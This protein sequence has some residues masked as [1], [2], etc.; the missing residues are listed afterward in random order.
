MAERLNAL[1]WKGSICESVSGVRIPLSPQ[2]M[3]KFTNTQ[4][5]NIENFHKAKVEA[6][7]GF[8]DFVPQEF[9]DDPVE[10]FER[11]GKNIKTGEIKYDDAGVVRE[12]PTAV[13][14]LPAWK[15]DDGKE[16]QTVGKRININKGEVGES[17]D[18]FHEYKILDRLNQMGLPS[19]R[20]IAKA[21]KSGVHII[22]MERIPGLR[23]SE[24]DSLNLKENGYSN[25]DIASLMAEA[26]LRM[27]E[28]KTQ[29]DEAGII[30]SWKLKDMVFEVD[31]ENKKIASMVPTDWERTKVVEKETNIKA[32]FC[33]PNLLEQRGEFLR[34][35]EK[36]S[37]QNPDEF[38]HDLYLKAREAELVDL[39]EQVWKDLD[40]TD[41][42][43]IVREG[44][45]RVNE[46]VEH[47]NKETGSNRDWRYLKQKIEQE[48]ELDASIILKH[49]GEFHLV[50][51]NT[52]LMVA[53]ALGITPKVL[54]VEI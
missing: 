7:F 5:S 25:E 6:A 42:Y 26:E 22:V 9:K 29:F 32:N 44:W 23:W 20:P 46:H 37:P 27:N 49:D 40:N 2:N 48:Q 50:S 21:E 15:N 11:E 4:D 35:G 43:D 12:D 19:A 3:E 53:R 34:V 28:L 16:V 38:A 31:V 24:K 30:R 17:G 36:Y 45:V 18:P 52:R 1:P 41:S 8:S 33:F 10:Y 39:S 51:G 54:L 47:T 13:K 14:D